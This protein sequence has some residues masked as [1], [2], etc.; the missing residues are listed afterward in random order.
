MGSPQPGQG[1]S[2]MTD[3]HSDDIRL[4]VREAYG[5][6]AEADD[7]GCGCGVPTSCCGT[8]PDLDLQFSVRLGYTAEDL[9]ALPEGAATRRPSR[10][11]NPARRSS[12][13]AA[14]VAWTASWQP[15][16][17]APREG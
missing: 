12:T 7:I 8:A 3:K 2:G 10:I 4:S 11:S 6:V 14:E 1:G 9:A 5:K 16:K 13:W 15:G 17:W